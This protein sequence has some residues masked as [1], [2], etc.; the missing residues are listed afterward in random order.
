MSDYGA[1]HNVIYLGRF[2]TH[3]GADRSACITCRI[4]ATPPRKP[5]VHVPG[6]DNL[7]PNL[8]P[9]AKL[10]ADRPGLP[11][12]ESK[13]MP[14][15][16]VVAAFAA[17]GM[18]GVVVDPEATDQLTELLVGAITSGNW[19][20]VAV[21]GVVLAVWLV[22][23]FGA[24]IVPWL[25]SRAAGVILPLVGG[26]GAFIAASLL[27]G[28]PLTWVLVM[29]AIITVGLGAIGLHSATKNAAQAAGVIR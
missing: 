3:S 6:H 7:P 16:A 24:P 25:G 4:R 22:R 21:L 2:E 1:H 29:K 18:F 10:A 11:A 5:L 8:S 14:A 9:A 17:A 23:K 28:T 27:A 19:A 26:A 20:L 12:K 13:A 15:L